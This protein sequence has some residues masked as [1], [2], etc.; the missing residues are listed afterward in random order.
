MPTIIGGF[1]NWMVPL[2]LGCPD[3]SFPR[4][5]N[6]RF[7]LLPTSLILLLDSCFVDS[8]GGTSWTVYPPLS[9]IGHPGSSVDLVIFRLHFAGI[10]SILGGI[11]FICTVKN[12][13]SR[14]I[15][16]EHINLFVWSVFVTVFLLVLSLPVLAGAITILLTDRNFNTRFFDPSCGG[17][18]LVY[19]HLFWFF[20]HPEVYILILPAFGILSHSSLCLTG[21]K[22]V[23]GS[24][25]IVYAILR[26]G[27]IG[28]VVWAHHIYTVGIDLDS[29]AYFTA[30]TM[31]IAVPTGVKVFSWLVTLYGSIFIFHPLLLWIIG[32]IFLF[33]VGGLTGLILSNSSLDIILHDSY[34]VV[35][36][37][38]YVLRLGAV[39]GIFCGIWLW[40]NFLFNVLFNK[41]LILLFFILIFFGVNLTFFP[42][43]FRG[44]QGYPRKYLDYSDLNRIWNTVSSFG[45]LLSIFSLVLFVYIIFESFFSYRL[46]FFDD[47]VIYSLESTMSRY[48]FSH[49]YLSSIYY[50][51]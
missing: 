28:C 45:S 12:L 44:L 10:S 6:L 37:F 31:V 19:Q 51:V 50:N 8:G 30:A 33:T 3:I 27:L 14:S 21:K 34:Y 16:L 25:G 5:N 48:V 36:H 46:V 39:F 23:F 32:F 2:I 4:L 22:E 11:N 43:H 1:G 9:T 26:I 17:N 41:G 35:R 38:H 13:R 15:S 24:L 18:P 42:L 20:G 47:K 40:W 7:W 49:S 29:R